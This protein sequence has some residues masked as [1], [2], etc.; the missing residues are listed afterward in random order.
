MK[1]Q[2]SA[3]LFSLIKLFKNA[4]KLDMVG[5]P[6]N[7]H[8]R[9]QNLVLPVVLTDSCWIW[10]EKG[11]PQNPAER[12]LDISLVNSL[13]ATPLLA[14]NKGDVSATLVQAQS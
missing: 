1:T 2:V 7:K 5:L 14:Q 3:F 8:R 12:I 9:E 6:V 11:D 4:L 13:S 10:A